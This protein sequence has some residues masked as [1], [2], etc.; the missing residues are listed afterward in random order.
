MTKEERNALRLFNALMAEWT[1]ICDEWLAMPTVELGIAAH[2]VR[3]ESRF[4][5]KLV[6][7]P[8]YFNPIPQW[9]FGGQTYTYDTLENRVVWLYGEERTTGGYNG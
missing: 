6:N 4:W 7:V 3:N 9:T 1:R 2:R 8:E 5:H